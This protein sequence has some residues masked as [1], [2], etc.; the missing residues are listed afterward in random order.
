MGH[1]KLKKK[2]RAYS[3][4]GAASVAS[5]ATLLELLRGAA[6]R[7]ARAAG[8]R[9]RG[10]RLGRR[11]AEG[12]GRAGADLAGGLAADARAAG[13]TGGAA[14]VDSRAGHLVAAEGGV[15]VDEDARVG[16][17]VGTG[18]RYGGRG[19][20]AAAGDGELVAGHVELGT[21]RAAGGVQGDGL[22]TE[23]V[24]ARGDVA[25]DLD[26]E[27]AAAGVKVLVA[28]V[29]AVTGA[30]RRALGPAG[31]EHLEPTGRA[32]GRLG[33][34]DL[35]QVGHHGAVV[36]PTDSLVGAGTVTI[37]LNTGCQLPTSKKSPHSAGIESPS[38]LTMVLL[39]N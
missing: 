3:A 32:V 36:G 11:R 2:K 22:R 7:V 21:A 38:L 29:V 4:V 12:A 39:L 15:D 24:V 34:G 9:S 23:K 16:G 10:G 6:A 31:L 37:L 26:V 35:G 5:A 30:A 20:A 1:G 27:L 19:G 8:G 33:V 17:R 25:G 28:P 18:E 14:G 13:G